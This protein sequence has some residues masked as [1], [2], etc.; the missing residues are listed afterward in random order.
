GGVEQLMH[1]QYLGWPDGQTQPVDYEG[2]LRFMRQL[3][4]SPTPCTV[5]IDRKGIRVQEN[6]ALTQ[7]VLNASC[8]KPD[9]TKTTKS[10]D[11]THTW[12]NN[13]TGWKILGGMSRDP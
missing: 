5:S 9:G 8:S 13:G 10:S 4:T 11:I 2:S 7:Y 6:T 12:V 1:R 3:I